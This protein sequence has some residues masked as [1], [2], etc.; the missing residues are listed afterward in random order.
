MKRLNRRQ[1]TPK[2]Q[3]THR[4]D[5]WGNLH[6]YVDTSGVT[7]IAPGDKKGGSYEKELD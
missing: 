4:G 3:R 2:Q 6:K 1:K 7:C 5:L